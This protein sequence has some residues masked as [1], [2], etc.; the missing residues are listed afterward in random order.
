MTTF[1]IFLAWWTVGVAVMMSDTKS[2]KEI[3]QEVLRLPII[4]SERQAN[5]F[6]LIGMLICFPI[7]M[8]APFKMLWFFCKDV[9]WNIR[10]RIRARKIA[11]MAQRKDG[12]LKR[13]LEQLVEKMK[14]K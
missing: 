6:I 10:L 5:V 8:A 7:V 1:L 11:K 13:E 4:G 3:K 14:G 9:V 12:E 2:F